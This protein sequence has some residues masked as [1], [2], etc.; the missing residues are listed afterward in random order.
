MADILAEAVMSLK[1]QDANFEACEAEEVVKS[2][3]VYNRTLRHDQSTHSVQLLFVSYDLAKVT[4]RSWN[5]HRTFRTRVGRSHAYACEHNPP[6]QRR[7]FWLGS[8]QTQR[9]KN[10]VAS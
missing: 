8:G 1:E 9:Q 6:C 5:N 7:R 2:A 3:G 10:R 4:R